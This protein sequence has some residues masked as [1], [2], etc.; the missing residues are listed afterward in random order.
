MVSVGRIDDVIIHSSGEKTVP[1]PMENTILSSQWLVIHLLYAIPFT[2]D[3]SRVEA[4]ILF[5]R[6][7]DF[8]GVLIEPSEPVEPFSPHE[9]DE[10]ID[11]IW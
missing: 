7:H 11:K 6:E 4:V 5:G 2:D 8:V 1:A 9:L 3:V 10:F